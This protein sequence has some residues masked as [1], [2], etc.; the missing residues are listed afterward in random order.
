MSNPSLSSAPLE[1]ITK[2]TIDILSRII[3]KTPLNHKL[4][5]KPPFRYL[6]DLITE[7]IKLTGAYQGLYSENEFN[8]E[9]IKEKDA[10]VSFL[11]K[12]ID[13]SRL[14][15]GAE[16]K[17][18]PLK[19]VA[20][21]EPEETNIFLQI[22]GKIAIKKVDTSVAVGKITGATPQ[23]APAKTAPE[24]PKPKPT[25][26]PAPTPATAKSPAPAKSPSP[27]PAPAPA[28]PTPEVGKPQPKKETQE[29][30]EKPEAI[31]PPANLPKEP[32]LEREQEE[33]QEPEVEKLVPQV[34]TRRERP[35][36]A[37]PP[38]P[39]LK[40]SEVVQEEPNPQTVPIHTDD[41]K[42]DED[43]DEFTVQTV[44]KPK[45]EK[46]MEDL[47]GEHGGLVQKMLQ[48]KREL[49]GKQVETK[50]KPSA[51]IG[52]NEIANLRTSI[53]SLC[54]STNPLGKTMDYLQEDVDAM[55]KELEIW[56]REAQNFKLQA[57]EQ[58]RLTAES[59]LPQE[60]R[61]KQI[62]SCIEEQ[63]QKIAMLKSDIFTND[64]LI[65]KL[66]RNITT[67]G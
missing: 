13:C 45:V 19:I 17:A 22:M 39:K 26:Q 48:N 55:N 65:E 3:K 34:T 62:E 58:E 42:K 49:E 18:N 57:Q 15:T 43:E 29:K 67:S 21:L 14:A 31:K 1:E 30:V 4:L 47:S 64:S 40:T 59:L 28:T 36:S 50:A 63:L 32:E 61:L 56:K 37:R 27:A 24:A 52:Q 20:G 23:T 38:P 9:N 10:K 25:P 33:A 7:T 8:S 44:E 12:I 46:S 51:P 60:E 2:K 5:S 41:G 16:I 6:H 54:K 53:Q 66:L 11:T 35:M